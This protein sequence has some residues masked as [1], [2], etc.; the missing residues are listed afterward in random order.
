MGDTVSDVIIQ[1]RSVRVLLAEDQLSQVRQQVERSHQPVIIADAAGNIL[2]L[3]AAVAALLPDPATRP[4]SVADLLRLFANSDEIERHL[5]DLV[6]NRRAWR[7]EVLVAGAG[8]IMTPLL[9]RA[10]P[11]FTA[12]D[13]TVGFV[14]LFTDLTERK[15]AEA[16][17]RGFQESVIKQRPVMSGK[18]DFVK[19]ICCSE[20]SFRRS[21]KTPSS[22]RSK[23]LIASIP[24]TCRRCW[25]HCALRSPGRPKYCGTSC[26]TRPA[27]PKAGGA[28]IVD[29]SNTPD[30]EPDD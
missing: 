19:P 24:P 22:R 1:F 21:S 5:E 25:R 10:D 6:V 11:V 4:R 16:S 29:V 3:N 13:R 30:S 12:L 23:S 27:E 9:V 28:K 26:G 7:G 15:A 14:L 17:R 20:T 2:K 18:L 8:G